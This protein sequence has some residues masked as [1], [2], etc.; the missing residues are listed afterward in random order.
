MVECVTVG[1]I[2]T[3]EWWDAGGLDVQDAGVH[4]FTVDLHH[5]LKLLV[6]NDTV[7]REG[8]RRR[9]SEIHNERDTGKSESSRLSVSDKWFEWST[10]CF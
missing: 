2:G 7:C 10:R 8:K 5:H 6:F 1:L 9:E 3:Q 4:H